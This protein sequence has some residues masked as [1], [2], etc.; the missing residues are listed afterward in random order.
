M[1]DYLKIPLAK[2]LD[3][4]RRNGKRDLGGGWHDENKKWHW[5][6]QSMRESGGCWGSEAFMVGSDNC[7]WCEDL[8]G[9]FRNV[10]DADDIIRLRH[11]GWY[12]DHFQDETTHGIVL[13]LPARNRNT[14]FMSACSDP[15]NKNAGIVEQRLYDDREDCARSADGLAEYYAEFC[16]EDDLKQAAEH[17][18]EELREEIKKNRAHIKQLVAGIRESQL[19]PAV[20]DEMRRTIRTLR[21]EC[22]DAIDRIAKI[23]AEPWIVLPH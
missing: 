20:C 8:D 6:P 15:W 13:Q 1:T 3:A 5:V 16:R 22:R 19:A 11:T 23:E 14:L 4:F 12:V 17:D 9:Y 2:R 18:M 7:R 21:Q 10:K